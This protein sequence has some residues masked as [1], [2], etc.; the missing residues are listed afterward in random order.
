MDERNGS[1]SYTASFNNFPPNSHP[2]VAVE[3]VS[4]EDVNPQDI[5]A[6]QIIPGRSIGPIIQ[7]IGTISERRRNINISLTL[8]PSGSPWYFT[9]SNKS[10]P[11]TIASGIVTGLLPPGIRASGWWI[12]GDTENWNWRNGFY[13]RS[14]SIVY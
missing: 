13:T 11:A 14:L 2:L 4:V 7:N 10:L 3:D 6:I 12:A 9:Y 5:H 1:I 8:Y